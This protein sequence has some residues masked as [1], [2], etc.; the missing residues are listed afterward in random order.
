MYIRHIEFI[1][2]RR[3]KRYDFSFDVIFE[4]KRI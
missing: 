2:A 4:V 1:L 3:D